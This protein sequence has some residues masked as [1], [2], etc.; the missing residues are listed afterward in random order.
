MMIDNLFELGL[1]ATL[2]SSV[3]VAFVLA[4]R[5]PVIRWV[6]ARWAYYLW[7]APLLGVLA[8]AIPAQ[9]LQRIFDV[10]DI[11]VPVVNVV[12]EKASEV[13]ELAAGPSEGG[14]AAKAKSIHPQDKIL[15]LVVWLLGGTWL[16]IDFAIRNIRYSRNLR[17]ASRLL[18]CEE[19]SQVRRR[20]GRLLNRPLVTIRMLS[21]GQGPA[22]AGLLRPVLFLPADFFH[23]FSTR[24]QT[25]VLAHEYQHL[26]RYDLVSLLL[27]RIFRCLF[28]FNPLVYAG[29]RYLQLDIELSVDEAVLADSCRAT[30]RHYGESLLLSAHREASFA[31]LAYSSTFGDVRKRTR[32][33]KHYRQ[34]LLGGFAG[35]L[36][37][38]TTIA[39]SVTF[40]IFGSLGFEPNL[41]IRE[42]LQLSL[43]GA[44]HQLEDA[45]LN[46]VGKQALRDRLINL[47][48]DF[49][50][51][52]LSDY[53]VARLNE[54]VALV[55]YELGEYDHAIQSYKKVI[56]LASGA[57]T[58]QSRAL[59]AIAKLHFSQGNYLGT[60][61][62]LARSDNIDPG[63]SSAD[64][65]ALRSRAFVKL[66]Q[67]NAGLHFINLAIRQAEVA[68]NQPVKDWLLLRT[69]LEWKLG[70]LT[71]AARSL[72]KSIELFPDSTYEQTLM[73]FNESVQDV[74]TPNID[75]NPMVEF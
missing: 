70:D 10:P 74:W 37:L 13:L 60:V 42:S 57:P 8:M 3:W 22:V 54:L 36:L 46:N 18:N 44:L 53:E 29:E 49:Q 66:Q 47:E 20:C 40:G 2:L 30:R 58:L 23:R 50:G 61:Q 17:K 72:E 52:A 69:S 68:G 7:L 15:L 25:L 64:K 6:G 48:K 59:E 28:W 63:A 11:E 75:K 41:E 9:P 19:A 51:Q 32:M 38:V 34:R 21:S 39:A 45:G 14:T 16:L 62:A 35:G 56:A 43:V 73:V 5:I 4:I 26:V 1:L 65:L 71:S 33:L 12:I 55:S 31:Q 27:A 67:W 24:Q